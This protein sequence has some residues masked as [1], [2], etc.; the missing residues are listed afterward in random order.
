MGAVTLEGVLATLD[1]ARRDR[2]AAIQRADVRQ[3]IEALTKSGRRAAVQTPAPH[4]KRPR[5]EDL[6]V[7]VFGT[8][9][10][11][12]THI[13][14][15]RLDV[16]LNSRLHWAAKERAVRHQRESV[17]FA[18]AG[19]ARLDGATRVRITREAPALLDTDNLAGACKAV[20]DEVAAW[21]GVTDAPGGPVEWVVQQL[22][23]EGYGVRLEIT[24]GAR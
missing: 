24:G 2:L 21:L 13:K 17:R 1:P 20:R 8:E 19:V 4:A 16:T 5:P 9:A 22:R 11:A 10:M 18:L 15:L 6:G 23:A 12:C 7:L 14:G 3:R